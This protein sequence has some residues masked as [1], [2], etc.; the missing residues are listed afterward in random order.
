MNITSTVKSQSVQA[1]GSILVT[2]EHTDSN[3][4]TYLQTYLST[5]ASLIEDVCLERGVQIQIELQR[6]ERVL[7]EATNFEIPLTP[8]EVM[9]RLSPAEWVAFQASTDANIVY[10]REVFNKTTQ[11]YRNDPLTQAGLQALVIAGILAS[12]RVGEV[13]DA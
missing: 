1:D 12:E 6:R 5:D 7:Q 13:L 4:R 9:R 8:V 10:F 2:E 11:I 3:G